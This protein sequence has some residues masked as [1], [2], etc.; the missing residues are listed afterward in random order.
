MKNAYDHLKENGLQDSES[1]S[2]SPH[3][4]DIKLLQRKRQ[5]A[6]MRRTQREEDLRENHP[7]F[8]TPLFFVGRESKFR[9]FCQILVYSRYDPMLRDPITGKE[10]KVRYKPDPQPDRLSLVHGLDHDPDHDVLLLLH[11]H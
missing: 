5:Q 6:E 3:D 11:D 8:D 9:R 4:F 1:T 10:R 2:R 7:F